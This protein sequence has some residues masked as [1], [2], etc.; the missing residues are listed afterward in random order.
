MYSRAEWVS[1]N[2]VTFRTP[3][4]SIF[5][6]GIEQKTFTGTGTGRHRHVGIHNRL[7]RKLEWRLWAGRRV[8]FIEETQLPK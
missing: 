8:V 6:G 1:Q 4:D 7:S 5:I 3:A 2:D